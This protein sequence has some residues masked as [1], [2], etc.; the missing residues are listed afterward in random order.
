MKGWIKR[1]GARI[2]NGFYGLLFGGITYKLYSTVGPS[3]VEVI[4][5]ADKYI[6]TYGLNPSMQAAQVGGYI[7]LAGVAL[8]ALFSVDFFYAFARN[9]EI[10]P[11][12]E[13]LIGLASK[14]PRQF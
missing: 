13:T 12:G 2:E 4:Q 9:R 5:E 10:G 8:S 11:I 6:K 3:A 1:N 14:I 7:V